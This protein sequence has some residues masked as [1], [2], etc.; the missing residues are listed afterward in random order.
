MAKEKIEV[1]V[2][3][4]IMNKMEEEGRTLS[5]LAEKTGMNYNT[6]H[7]CIKRKLFLLSEENLFK[8]NNALGTD[9][10]LS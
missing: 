8:I 6:I 9:F 5:W 1:D 4:L 7:S 2:R 3:D 10:K